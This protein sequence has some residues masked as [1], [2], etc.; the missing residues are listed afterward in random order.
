MLEMTGGGAAL[1]MLLTACGA[2]AQTVADPAPPSDAFNWTERPS[3]AE[4]DY[5]YRVFGPARGSSVVECTLNG[6]RRPR[7][8]VA[9][10]QQAPR[11]SR[12]AIEL[13]ELYRAEKLDNAGAQLT[14]RRVRFT[15]DFIRYVARD[16]AFVATELLP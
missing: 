1:A 13:A 8:C 14:G 11:D 15:F 6:A 5:A 9:I 16:Q 7:D 12:L 2:T 10:A 4:I 3:P